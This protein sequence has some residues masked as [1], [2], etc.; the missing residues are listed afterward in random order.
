[1]KFILLCCL[2]L[3]CLTGCAK[4]GSLPPKEVLSRAIIANAT[5][6]SVHYLLHGDIFIEDMLESTFTVD[7]GMQHTWKEISTSVELDYQRGAGDQRQDVNLQGN[8]LYIQP[9]TIFLRI[10]TLEVEPEIEGMITE[11]LKDQ[12]WTLPSSGNV[13]AEVA[14]PNPQLLKQ[15]IEA[16]RITRDQGL[17]NFNGDS[18]YRYD[19]TIDPER[20]LMFVQASAEEQGKTTD[21]TAL[22]QILQASEIQGE[23]WIDTKTFQT[24]RIRWRIEKKESPAVEIRM[25]IDFTKHNREPAISIPKDSIVFP[26]AP[27]DIL[28]PESYLFGATTLQISNADSQQETQELIDVL[29]SESAQQ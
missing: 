17:G 15:Q 10:D 4:Q 20:L 18:V 14:T 9:D 23:L 13:K 6:D 28:H 3:V 25:T 22:Q 19:T 7:G 11:A 12:W 5:L 2:G 21:I 1:M 24:K 29:N 26:I 16:I 8:I 27:Q